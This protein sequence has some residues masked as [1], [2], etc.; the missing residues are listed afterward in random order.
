MPWL[1]PKSRVVIKKL[2]LIDVNFIFIDVLQPVT[3]EALGDRAVA[4]QARKGKSIIIEQTLCVAIVGPIVVRYACG[5]DMSPHLRW[6]S[7]KLLLKVS[8]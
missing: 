2:E 6:G 8:D 5:M 4:I 7:I 1:L 3:K